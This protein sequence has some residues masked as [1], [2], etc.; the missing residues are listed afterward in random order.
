MLN[1]QLAN[2]MSESADWQRSLEVFQAFSEKLTKE[3]GEL[4][5]FVLPTI[6]LYLSLMFFFSL[7][8]DSKRSEGRRGDSQAKSASSEFDSKS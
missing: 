6:F 8:R 7:R 1:I 4:K 5:V 2:L 3:S